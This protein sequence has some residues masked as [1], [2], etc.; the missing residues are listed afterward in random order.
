MIVTLVFIIFVVLT[1]FLGALNR[2]FSAVSAREL[3]RRSREGDQQARRLHLVAKYGHDV[4]IVFWPAIVFFCSVTIWTASH[5]LA[6][7]L[8]ICAIILLLAI[9][10]LYMPSAK[11]PKIFIKFSTKLAPKVAR[12]IAFVEPAVRLV[13]PLG[14]RL[15]SHEIDTLSQDDL[16]ETLKQQRGAPGQRIGNDEISTTIHLL[17]ASN[18]LIGKHTVPLESTKVVSV[19]ESIGPILINELHQTK[20]QYFPVREAKK[21]NIIG[22]FYIGDLLEQSEGGKVS[23]VVDSHLFFV[24]EK[25]PLKHLLDAFIK[26]KSHIFMVID[27]KQKILGVVSM[28]DALSK[29]LGGSIVGNFD[30]YES[31]ESVSEVLNSRQ[32][33]P[34][35]V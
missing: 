32:E 3:S 22:T 28:E 9:T 35:Q 11:V 14:E 26:T 8:A 31:P 33:P 2:T 19:E 30:S 25:Q 23:D 7:G 17:G 21:K 5:L 15:S 4:G 27:D 24:H 6:P 16:V 10:F 12:T 20:Q 13:K 18:D 34:E 1:I 29:L